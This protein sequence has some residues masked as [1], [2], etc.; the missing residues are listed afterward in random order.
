MAAAHDPYA[1]LRSP[2]YRRLLTG[3]VLSAF[4][5]SMQSLVIGWELYERTH[6][7]AAIGLTGLAQFFPVVLLALPAGHAADRFSLKRLFLL[8]QAILALSS[9]GLALVSYFAAPV[10]L[11]YALLLLI[12]IGRA[13]SAPARWSILPH[14]I[15]P[16]ALANAVTWNS[17]GWQVAS[18]TGPTLG[19]F[20]IAWTGRAAPAYALTAMCCGV[21]GLLVA[22]IRL[23]P[24]TRSKEPM[25]FQSLLAGVRFVFSRRLILATITLDLFAVLLG[26][27]TALLPIYASEILQTGPKGLGWLRAAP[28]IGALVMAVSLAHLPPFKRAG[29]AL[30]LS[31]AGFG[32]ATIV[33]GLST[34]PL[35]SFIMLALTGALDNVS[36]VVRGT[37]VQTLTPD[38][39]RGRVSAVNTI[40]I[41]S[42]NE[43]GEFESGM[44]AELFGNLGWNGPVTSVVVGGIG[45]ILVVLWVAMKWPEVRR[46]G[47]LHAPKAQPPT[48][49]LGAVSQTENDDE[50]ARP[51]AG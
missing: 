23:Q 17:S 7:A 43:L 39:M 12:G 1:A 38:E 13:F 29:R 4:G 14:L 16:E 28:S 15:P 34:D 19:G 48:L 41:V 18:M 32:V 21:C 11:V 20:I 10:P 46:L 24:M 31:V 44:T 51:V 6:S 49:P 33:F 3:N 47:P 36:I 40:F 25:T 50:A 37:L 5:T 35:L 42:S 9:I 30:L 45:T 22:G 8:A 27:A 26:G 2:D